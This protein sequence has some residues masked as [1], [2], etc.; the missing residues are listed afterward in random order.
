MNGRGSLTRVI[1]ALTSAAI[2][3]LVGGYCASKN[4]WPWPWFRYAKSG[5]FASSVRNQDPQYNPPKLFTFD[6][7]GRL[8]SKIKAEAVNCPT[9]DGRTAVLVVAG[10]S[11][12]ANNGGQPTI[13]QYGSRILNYFD[14]RC[15]AAAS[16]LLGSSGINGE[17]WTET[18]NLLVKSGTFD[19]IFLVPAAVDNTSI[20][21]W[22]AGGD[23]NL[24]LRHTVQRLAASGFKVTHVLWHQGETD[25]AI[26]MSEEEYRMHFLS[27]VASLRVAGITTPVY[28]SVASKCLLAGPYS[29]GN[30]VALAQAALPKSQPGLLSG[31]DS[32]RLL[33]DVDRYD[34]CHFSGS[35]TAKMAL[36]WA[37]LLSSPPER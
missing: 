32:D 29:E 2:L 37:T 34:G 11:N 5:L 19:R 14:G 9:Q 26:G 33:A 28:V 18:A 13:S 12:A 16:P 8:S 20:A 15:Y 27:F 30:P 22:S 4:I 17:F 21:R 23:L 1:A 10:Q 7:Y 6:E 24:M 3:Y 31:L 25:A 36:G 35:G